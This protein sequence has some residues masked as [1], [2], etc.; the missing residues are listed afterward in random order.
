MPKANLIKRKSNNKVKTKQ[1]RRDAKR[2]VLRYAAAAVM[3][4]ESRAAIRRGETL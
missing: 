1:T 3:G 4:G 2:F